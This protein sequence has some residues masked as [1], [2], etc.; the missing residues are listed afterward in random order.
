[1][2]I[3]IFFLV[4]I[5]GESKAR[6]VCEVVVDFAYKRIEFSKL[7][8][9]DPCIPKNAPFTYQSLDVNVEIGVFF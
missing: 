3:V 7:F 8:I 1:M 9:K 5:C 6:S 2:E 4:Q